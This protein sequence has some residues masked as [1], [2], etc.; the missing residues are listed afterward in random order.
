MNTPPNKAYNGHAQQKLVTPCMLDVG[1]YKMKQRNNI[2]I[3]TLILVIISTRTYSQNSNEYK[4]KLRKDNDKELV[5]Y[6][7][8]VTLDYLIKETKKYKGICNFE[9]FKGFNYPKL[10]CENISDNELIIS[11]DFIQVRLLTKPFDTLQIIKNLNTDSNYYSKHSFYGLDEL[12][13]TDLNLLHW[14]P[15]RELDLISIRINNY[16]IDLPKKHYEGFFDANITCNEEHCPTNA[17]LT[18]KGEII[19]QMNNGHGA[20]F[21]YAIF[22]FN[23]QGELIKKIVKNVM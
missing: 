18:E 9:F 20:G 3:L 17:Y 4:M 10:D 11:N 22:V 7:T 23:S 13:I 21:Y 2:L 16:E 8:I 1:K 6:D 14:K 15:Q 12:N 5:L 19:L